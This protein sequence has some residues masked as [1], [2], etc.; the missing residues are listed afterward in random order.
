[1][2]LPPPAPPTP[3]LS[4]PVGD[5]ASDPVAAVLGNATLGPGWLESTTPA[6]GPLPP[7]LGGAGGGGPA[8]SGAPRPEPLRPE[9][10]LLGPELPA[11]DGGG[12]T[13]LLASKVFPALPLVPES[14][15]G[16]G[17]TPG[18]EETATD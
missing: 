16:G 15:G 17:T 3:G 10:E 4:P 12:G 9:P 13:T 11:R 7:V 14:E 8:S 18:A 6:L 5:M 1:M 2:L